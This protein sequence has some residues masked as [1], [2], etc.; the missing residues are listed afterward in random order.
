MEDPLRDFANSRG[1]AGVD[2]GGLGV[3]VHGLGAL[4]LVER[5]EALMRP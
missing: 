3:M 5:R 1:I 2:S 4:E